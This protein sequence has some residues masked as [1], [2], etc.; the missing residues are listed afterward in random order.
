MYGVCLCFG[1]CV[2]AF[3]LYFASASTIYYTMQGIYNI[4]LVEL[5]GNPFNKVDICL[6]LRIWIKWLAN[7]FK[8]LFHSEWFLL[9]L[10]K[11]KCFL[12]LYI[13]IVVVVVFVVVEWKIPTWFANRVKHIYNTLRYMFVFKIV[14]CV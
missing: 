12:C 6:F 10:I 8:I 14:S 5:K 2:K 3:R 9:L 7:I 4:K 1:C 11:Y 13:T